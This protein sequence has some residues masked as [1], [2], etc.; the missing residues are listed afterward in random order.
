LTIRVRHRATARA[1]FGMSP[2]TKVRSG[3]GCIQCIQ[4]RTPAHF[5]LKPKPWLVITA[6]HILAP[7]NLIYK[8]LCL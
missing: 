1:C 7:R 6:R 2:S 5:A 4:A 8:T 3:R